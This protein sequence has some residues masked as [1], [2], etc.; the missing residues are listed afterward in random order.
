MSTLLDLRPAG[1]RSV[2]VELP[3]NASVRKLVVAAREQIA[4]LEEVVAGHD[5]V[6]LVWEPGRRPPTDLKDRLAAVLSS[7]HRDPEPRT[8]ALDVRYDGPDLGAVA[9]ACNMSPE[10]V[11]R[12]HAAAVY[13]VGFL[14]FAPGFAYLLGG[15][16]QL[17][18]PRRDSPRARVPAGSLALAGEYSAIYPTASPG[19]WHL[20]GSCDATLFDLARPEPALLTTG[21]R[22][23][24]RVGGA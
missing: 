24:L 8:I 16:P 15:D 1:T 2:L 19:G 22:V 20:L 23:E 11:V 14:G 7:R 5:T 6:L 12:R 18:P 17:Q 3:G 4:G 9:D 13:E 21:T 10:E